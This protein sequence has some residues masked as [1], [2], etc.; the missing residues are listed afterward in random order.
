MKVDARRLIRALSDL[1]EAQKKHVRKAVRKNTEEGAR[2]VSRLAPNVTGRTRAEIGTKFHDDGM[3]GEIVVVDSDAPRKDKDR[4]Y[5]IE[6]G[7]SG[8]PRGPMAGFHHVR[9]TKVYLGKRWK[10]RVARAIRRAVK[11]VSGNG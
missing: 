11:E 3:T 2:V 7:R 8:G 5:S 10:G 6:H 4:A 1:P 9:S